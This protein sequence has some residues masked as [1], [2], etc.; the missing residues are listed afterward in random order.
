[1]SD[2]AKN[3]VSSWQFRTV[4]YGSCIAV[5]GFVLCALGQHFGD[6]PLLCKVGSVTLYGG[7]VA[8]VFGVVAGVLTV[9]WKWVQ[10]ALRD[11][12]A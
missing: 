3:F 10:R 1:M 5:L 9:G 2:G 8:A 11:E 12:G 4:L 6:G 7:D